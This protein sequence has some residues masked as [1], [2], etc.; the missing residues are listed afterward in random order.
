VDGLEL[1]GFLPVH[2]EDKRFTD[3]HVNFCRFRA[4]LTVHA[5]TEIHEQHLVRIGVDL[6]PLAEFL[7]ILQRKF[8][9]PENRGDVRQRTAVRSRQVKPE[10]LA[11][12]TQLA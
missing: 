6:R 9:Q 2:S 3:V 4:G 10:E 7:G 5:S 11:A 12:G 1:L 8:V